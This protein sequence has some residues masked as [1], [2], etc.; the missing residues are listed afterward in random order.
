ME[1]F[2][3][4][5]RVITRPWA[6][7]TTYRIPYSRL[8]FVYCQTEAI[9]PT[10][11]FEV[12]TRVSAIRLRRVGSS[13]RQCNDDVLMARSHSN[14]ANKPT[15]LRRPVI[16]RRPTS[17][18]SAPSNASCRLRGRIKPKSKPN[19]SLE[20]HHRHN[21]SSSRWELR[22]RQGV[23]CLLLLYRLTPNLRN[24]HRERRWPGLHP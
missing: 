21:S 3:G 17:P 8:S 22:D 18:T 2:F 4:L 13:L 19:R 23:P 24:R 12:G 15:A 10:L 9:Y 1:C 16:F 7:S 20:L 11:I 14:L 6:T 5:T